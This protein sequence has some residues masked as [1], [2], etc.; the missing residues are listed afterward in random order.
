AKAQTPHTSKR[1][2]TPGTGDLEVEWT[3]RRGSPLLFGEVPAFIAQFEAD[4][5]GAERSPASPRDQSAQSGGG[6]G[7]AFGRRPGAGA[8]V[9]GGCDP[10]AADGDDLRMRQ[11]LRDIGFADAAGGAI[12]HGRERTTQGIDDGQ[13]AGLRRREELHQFEAA[14]HAGDQV[15]GGLDTR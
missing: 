11:P 7:A 3:P 1:D 13:A 4:D 10:G 9:P 15:G 12:A 8:D 14:G 6:A 5:G 2:E